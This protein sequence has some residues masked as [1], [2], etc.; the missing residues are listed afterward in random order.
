MCEVVTLEYG[1]EEWKSREEWR[2]GGLVQQGRGP[3]AEDLIAGLLDE[4]EEFTVWVLRLDGEETCYRLAE[5]LTQETIFP[6]EHF[7]ADHI[8]RGKDTVGLLRTRRIDLLHEALA[9]YALYHRGAV[10]DN[11]NPD[12]FPDLTQWPEDA[13]LRPDEVFLF[14]WHDGEPLFVLRE[15]VP[16]PHGTEYPRRLAEAREWFASLPPGIAEMDVRDEEDAVSVDIRPVRTPEAAGIQIHIDKTSGFVSM[17]A[18]HGCH[19]DDTFW[20]GAIPLR[21]VCEA[22]AS[23]RLT[24]RIRLWRGEETSAEGALRVE[25]EARP[26]ENGWTYSFRKSIARLLLGRIVPGSGTRIVRY[27]PY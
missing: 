12:V 6:G 14:F 3:M 7:F 20:E 9:G 22:I 24:E 11:R 21:A 2:F 16:P 13:V 8:W 10:G 27:P 1:Y 18:G 25:G 23:G 19:L 4:G 15:G 17:G 5:R 26:V